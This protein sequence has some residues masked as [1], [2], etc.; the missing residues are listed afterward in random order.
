MVLVTMMEFQELLIFIS[1]DLFSFDLQSSV[2]LFW[3]LGVGWQ[4][5][6]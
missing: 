4:F 1:V 2:H 5:F 3:F 6:V